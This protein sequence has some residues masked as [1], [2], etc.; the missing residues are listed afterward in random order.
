MS[1]TGTGS[2]LGGKGRLTAGWREGVLVRASELEALLAW[3]TSSTGG[4]SA[5]DADADVL[6]VAARRHLVAA[7]EAALGGTHARPVRRLWLRWTGAD[8]ERAVS[9]LDA[10]EALLLQLAPLSYL[11]GQVPRLLVQVRKLPVEDPRRLAGE[12]VL[13]EVE[14]RDLNEVDRGYLVTAVREAAHADSLDLTRVRSF[15]N[16][17]VVVTLVELVLALAIAVL[18]ALSPA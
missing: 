2:G 11:R 10:A 4:Q 7:R 5:G 16:L 14:L 9:N 12:R 13:R 1:G 18:G 6:R 17:V 3:L 15:R 8:L